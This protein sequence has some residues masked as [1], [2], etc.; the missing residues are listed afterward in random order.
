MCCC[1]SACPLGENI[2]R[3]G[4]SRLVCDSDVM[5]IAGLNLRI[6]FLFFFSILLCL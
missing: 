1:K 2:F 4:H 6:S 5:M 3:G